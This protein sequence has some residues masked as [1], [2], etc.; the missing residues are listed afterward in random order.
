MKFVVG[1]A[2]WLP[3]RTYPARMTEQLSGWRSVR[4]GS[5]G[6]FMYTVYVLKNAQ[7]KLYKGMTNDFE[8]RLKEHRS[9]HTITTSRMGE[10]EVVY[11]ELFQTFE[12]AHAREKYFK[13][14]AGRKFLR[15]K[16]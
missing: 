4:A 9:G 15:S 3:A 6:K 12:E 7:G 2:Q 8:R 10:L 13:T 14:A 1:I 5:A 16:I 11:K